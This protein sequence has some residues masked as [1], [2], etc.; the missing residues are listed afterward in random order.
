LTPLTQQLAG[1]LYRKDDLTALLLNPAAGPVTVRFA[2]VTRGKTAHIFPALML[3]DWGK[4]H[5]TPA[6]YQWI[7]EQGQHFP[8]AEVFGFDVTG[9]ETQIFL[10][11]L[12]IFDRLPFY[13]FAGPESPLPDGL[14][15]RHI[16]V[17]DDE[18]ES[19]PS[20]R[21]APADLTG[22]IQ[23]ADVRWWQVNRHTLADYG[24]A[25]FDFSEHNW[26]R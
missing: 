11:A 20:P 22:P 13:V 15:V 2:L 19:R 5:N 25:R 17:S 24:F 6:L 9:E 4:E 16:F 21:E 23:R 12:E 8:R 1:D 14:Q 10:R 7:F 3:D 18:Q 26:R